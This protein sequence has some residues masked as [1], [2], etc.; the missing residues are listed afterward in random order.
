MFSARR[1][2]YSL[3]P[4]HNNSLAVFTLLGCKSL[5]IYHVASAALCLPKT[6]LLGRRAD[7][8]PTIELT[9]SQGS[10]NLE[11]KDKEFGA[12]QFFFSFSECPEWKL[13]V[14]NFVLV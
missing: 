5:K 1:A 6:I 10:W 13:E 14:I 11:M 4:F 3:S 7:H 8:S 12:F 9:A 2:H